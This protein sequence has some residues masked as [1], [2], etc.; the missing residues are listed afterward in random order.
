MLYI[1]ARLKYLR[2][3]H[4][5]KVL[6]KKGAVRSLSDPQIKFHLIDPRN[7]AIAVLCAGIICDAEQASGERRD[8]KRRTGVWTHGQAAFCKVHVRMRN[9]LLAF[10]SHL[11]YF[12]SFYGVQFS[13]NSLFSKASNQETPVS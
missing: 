13:L 10:E 9:S 8:R 12:N 11:P 1:Q 7:S 2:L 5:R 6:L 4:Q 3:G